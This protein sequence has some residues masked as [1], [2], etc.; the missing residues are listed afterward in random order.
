MESPVWLLGVRIGY[1]V[2]QN[3]L[4][5]L[6]LLATPGQGKRAPTL[7]SIRDT[8]DDAFNN[9]LQHRRN[10]YSSVAETRSLGDLTT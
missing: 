6:P 9:S 8:S 2:C 1:I 4:L 3:L 10:S 7:L 5:C